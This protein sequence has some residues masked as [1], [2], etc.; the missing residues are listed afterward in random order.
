MPLLSP[1]LGTATYNLAKASPCPL[2]FHMA[3]EAG[4]DIGG[5]LACLGAAGLLVLGAPLSV[6]LLL[7]APGVAAGAFL[8]RRQYPR[9]EAGTILTAAAMTPEAASLDKPPAG[10]PAVRPEA[11]RRQRQ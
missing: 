11:R 8:L 7:G 1:V 3:T 9:A 6:A 5:V 4:W 2:R 10:V